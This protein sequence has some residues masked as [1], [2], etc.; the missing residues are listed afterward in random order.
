MSTTK[1]QVVFYSMYGHIYRMA[2]AVAEGARSVKGTAVSVYQVAELVREQVLLDRSAY[3]RVS[4]ASPI[5]R[6]N[7]IE[8]AVLRGVNEG[9]VKARTEGPAP[10]AWKPA[11]S[12]R[13]VEPL[14]TQVPGGDVTAL[15]DLLAVRR[16]IRSYADTPL[17]RRQLELFLQLTARASAAVETPGLGTTSLRPYPSGGA[18]YPLEVYPVVLNV[19][20]LARGFYY[21]HPFHH[22][23]SCARRRSRRSRRATRGSS[24]VSSSSACRRP[25]RCIR[26]CT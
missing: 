8:T 11:V 21:Y 20:S 12:S 10:D 19:R 6:L 15:V 25:A 16:S 24:S 18:R 22:R 3:R 5:A 9:G 23:A 4:K 2:E 13:R 17:P 7:P 1:V 26:R 14:T